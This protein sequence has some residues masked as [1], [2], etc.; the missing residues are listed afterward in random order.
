MQTLKG[1]TC[2]FAG[3]TA[4]D[5]VAAVKALCAGGMNVVMMTHQASRA[6][7]LVDEVNGMNLPG[8]CKAVGA[9]ESGPAEESPE[10]YE[11]LVQEFGSVDV[12][13]ANTGGFGENIPMEELTGDRLLRDVEHLLCGAFN[14]LRAALPSL[15]KSKAPRVI[16]MSTTEGVNGGVHESFS[17]AV[18][19]GAVHSL[20]LNAAARLA[21]EHITV[22]CIAKGAIPRIEGLHPGDADPADFLPSIPMGRIGTPEELAELICFLASEESA[23]LTGQ[24]IHLTGGL[25][26]R[27]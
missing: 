27:R 24:T 22:N 7:A 5:G 16:F 20:A 4:G 3:A 12:I 17:N 13:I 1:R 25:E 19:K 26:L 21:G 14:M 18:A 9:L 11:S 15:R 23:Y 2:V 8:K 6:Q 10:I